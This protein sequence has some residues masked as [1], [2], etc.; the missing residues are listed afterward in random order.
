[1]Q[2]KE[3][4]YGTVGVVLVIILTG[5]FISGGS[6]GNQGMSMMGQNFQGSTNNSN[7]V[8]SSNIDR[9]FIEEMIPHHQ[10]AIIMAE[11]ALQKGQHDEIKSLASSIKKSQS[12]EI[13]QMKAWYKDWY[14]EDVSEDDDEDSGMM[15]QMH[16]GM[17][18]NN[19]DMTNLENAADFD[20]TF[21]EEMIPHHQ[22][23]VMMANMLLQGTNRPEMK[24]LAKDIITAQT[25]EIKQMRQWYSDWE[26][27]R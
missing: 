13:T 25:K 14:N 26:Y 17:M 11:I 10:D 9:H 5:I 2:K 24:K 27:T 6:F 1:M 15:G 22:M 3:I 12:K 19:T 23:A 7:N 8:M 16:G 4:L 20:K 21:I 18:D